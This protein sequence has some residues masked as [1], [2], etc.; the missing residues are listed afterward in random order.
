[1]PWAPSTCLLQAGPGGHECLV[2]GLPVPPDSLFSFS[3]ESPILAIAQPPPF[4]LAD[5]RQHGS[6]R[7]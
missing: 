5:P 3:Q 7:W 6:K 4:P 2:T 1:M